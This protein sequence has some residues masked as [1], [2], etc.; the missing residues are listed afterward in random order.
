MAFVEALAQA[1]R[2][3]DLRARWAAGYEQMLAGARLT[4]R[5]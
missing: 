1:E 2:N 5:L 3:T 4:L